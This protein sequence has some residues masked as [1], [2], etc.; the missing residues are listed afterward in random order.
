MSVSRQIAYNLLWTAE[1]GLDVNH[2]FPFTEGGHE[3]GKADRVGQFVNSSVKLKLMRRKCLFQQ[4]QEL[5]TEETA[6]R[7]YRQEEFLVLG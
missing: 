2:P 5:A 4:S 6:Q 1:R 3:L 7:L